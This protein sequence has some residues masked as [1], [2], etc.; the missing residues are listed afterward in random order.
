MRPGAQYLAILVGRQACVG[1]GK[2]LAAA[3]QPKVRVHVGVHQAQ[4][5]TV[6]LFEDLVAKRREG[7]HVEGAHGL[8]VAGAGREGNVAEGHAGGGCA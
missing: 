8:V 2:V 7:G 1:R 3:M 6:L 4:K 5:K